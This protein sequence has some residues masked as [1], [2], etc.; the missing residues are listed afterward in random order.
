MSEKK[1]VY[2][3]GIGPGKKECLTL[4]AEAALQ[5][6]D[7]IIGASRILDSVKRLE[8]PCFQSYL[9]GEIHQWM[10]EHEEYHTIAV[11]LSGDC[12]FY[13]GARKLAEELRE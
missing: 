5:K 2:L 8:K 10:E 13:S 11:V 1:N 9:P 12:G 7:C 3:V 6:C 4:E